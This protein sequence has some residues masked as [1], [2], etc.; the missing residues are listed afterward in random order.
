VVCEGDVL[1]QS[2]VPDTDVQLTRV[3]YVPG[4]TLNLLSVSASTEYGVNI[5][6]CAKSCSFIVGGVVYL[7]GSMSDGLYLINAPPA[8]VS[9]SLSAQASESVQLWH[10]RFGHLGFTNL[11]KVPKMTTGVPDFSSSA[12]KDAAASVCKPC[13]EGKLTR[14][15]LVKSNSPPNLL[16]HVLSSDLLGPINPLRCPPK[17]KPKAKP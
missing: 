4:A 3:L 14:K 12:I 15:P 2:K 17:P 1:L 8:P 5:E 6:F 11:S 7:K 16:L 13:I 9:I 10:E